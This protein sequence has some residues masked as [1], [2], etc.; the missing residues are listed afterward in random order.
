MKAEDALAAW[1]AK[2]ARVGEI[3]RDGV[4]ETREAYYALHTWILTCAWCDHNVLG[5]TKGL[6]LTGMQLHYKAFG[7]EVHA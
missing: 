6:A 1:D 5:R 2:S 3:H 7:I 4:N